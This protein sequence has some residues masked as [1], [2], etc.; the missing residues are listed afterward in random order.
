[1]PH[2]VLLAAIVLA[3]TI[4]ALVACAGAPIA[5]HEPQR[6]TTAPRL[7]D[8]GITHA[9]VAE[10]FVT[11]SA[12]A[13]MLHAPAAWRAPDGTTWLLTTATQGE[14]LLIHDGDTGAPLATHGSGGDGAGQFRS[15]RGIVVS[16]DLVFVVE[17]D[18]RRVQ[19]IEL[20]SLRTLGTLGS[21]ELLQPHGV[22]VQ[23]QGEHDV[24]L[25]V[26]DA[27]MAGEDAGGHALM[28][29]LAQLERRLH[30][31]AV[32]IDADGVDARHAGAFGDTSA[33]GAIRMPESLQ[34]DP[35]HDR[36]LISDKD[37]TTGTSLREYDIAGRFRGRNVGR[38]IFGAQT[39]GLALWACP[40][41]SGYWLAHDR[42][43][44]RSLFHI[45]DRVT[46]EHIGAFAGRTIANTS[47][48]WL[49]QAATTR[50]PDGVFYAVHDS[51]AVG[52][53]DWRDIARTLKLRA[54]CTD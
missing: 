51:R 37:T 18:N 50:F 11:V 30:R 24:D 22:W 16:G 40:D 7:A 9:T 52:A 46:L 13:D 44:D 1:M 2:R 21:E 3:A 34:G 5:Q 20:P 15:P 12:P 29:T 35:A 25:L 38:D 23:P 54:R 28:P 8:A 4:L 14:R 19:V 17:R 47:G 31:Y 10:A 42:F 49:Q 41:G 53:F 43:R 26:T 32:R 27:Y 48:V 45:F 33:A 6:N 39:G 36:L